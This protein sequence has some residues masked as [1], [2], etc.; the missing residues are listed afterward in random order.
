MTGL[1]I[2]DA[3]GG[4]EGPENTGATGVTLAELLEVLRGPD[5]AATGGG[6]DAGGAGIGLEPHPEAGAGVIELIP[7]E[8]QAKEG[9]DV[10]AETNLEGSGGA[11]LPRFFPDAE[12]TGAVLGADASN[13]PAAD[14]NFEAAVPPTAT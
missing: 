14:A 3:G 7:P 12:V 8:P 11:T 13:L 4:T 5:A 9:P 6:I 1:G 10:G 2:D